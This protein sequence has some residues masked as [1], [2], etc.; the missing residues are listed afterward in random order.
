MTGKIIGDK[1]EILEVIGGGGMG[2]IYKARHTLMKRIVAIKMMHPQYVSSAGNLQ[3]FQ[4]EAQAA[5]ALSHPN[6]LT[7]YDFGLTPEGAPYLVM[8]FLEGTNLAEVLDQQGFLAPSR[9]LHI[10]SQ[11]AAGLAH[12][13]SKGVIH[14]DLKPGNLMLVTVENDTD[15]VK[16]VDF[17]IAKLTMPD[18]EAA[19][20]TRTGEVFG[21][22]L[23]MSPE[24]CR[25]M[26]MDSRSDIYSLGCVMYRALSGSS[27]FVGQDPM[28]CMYKHV[29][30][31]PPA[32]FD[33]NPDSE[34][35]AAVEEVVLRCL[36]KEPEK[37][38]Q[39]MLELKEALDQAV[40][41]P[42]TVSSGARGQSQ[43]DQAASATTMALPDQTGKDAERTPAMPAKT[44][45]NA[46]ASA[47]QS[48]V[49]TTG[50][51]VAATDT[52][53]TAD[54]VAHP[55]RGNFSDYDRRINNMKLII[56]LMFVLAIFVALFIMYSNKQKVVVTTV[57]QV[58]HI[59]DPSVDSFLDE[60]QRQ[61]D[62]GNFGKAED[63]IDKALKKY[64]QM[65]QDRE[66]LALNLRADARRGQFKLA[67]AI[68]DYKAV[69]QLDGTDNSAYAAHAY[70]G[71]GEVYTKQSKFAQAKQSLE[72]AHAIDKSFTGDSYIEV[73]RTSFGL[74]N[75]ML[76]E[77]EF[78]SATKYLKEALAT[79]SAAKG[80]QAPETARVHNALAQVYQYQRKYKDAEKEYAK[81]QAIREAQ[82]H[83]NNAELADTLQCQ[84]TLYFTLKDY[85]K[86]ADKLNK[87]LQLYVNTVGENNLSVATNEFCLGVLYDQQ[88]KY[89]K[90]EPYYKK[91]L[92]IQKSI[93][94]ETDPKTLKTANY[95]A[96]VLKKLNK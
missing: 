78:S 44:V 77:G 62:Q 33:I 88:G 28:Q 89:A 26:T 64:P 92:T 42:N 60:A 96:T 57:N 11:A 25:G 80:A 36:A 3:R 32:I 54:A 72:K 5:S 18:G 58:N 53:V 76:A 1:Y 6:I 8:D 56:G 23:Y 35:P 90:A 47:T 40:N 17:G 22:P 61:I 10:F 21:S 9:A 75:L 51:V 94:G 74:G 65:H 93:L 7:V 95:Y 55:L 20:L 31:M 27:P 41:A 79:I 83:R 4:L 13:H 69:L 67:G 66:E 52:A 49:T 68:E 38:F 70:N 19:N 84:G 46:S 37:R 50:A 15:F 82:P 87:S 91:A 16:I 86:A 43:K 85:A 71:L 63:Q 34:V 29:N 14:R 48:P 81:A 30:E 2:M 12:A 24:Q 73:A 59:F 39:T 45:E